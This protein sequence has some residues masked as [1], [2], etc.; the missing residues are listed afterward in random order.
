MLSDDS[1]GILMAKKRRTRQSNREYQEK[2]RRE[3]HQEQ[4]PEREYFSVIPKQHGQKTDLKKQSHVRQP[5]FKGY[6]RNQKNSR[7][8]EFR[9]S[10][11][12]NNS[13]NITPVNNN[14]RSEYRQSEERRIQKNRSDA[15]RQRKQKN[16]RQL[17]QSKEQQPKAKQGFFDY[18]LIFIVIFLVMF[19]LLMLYTA[20]IY[21]SSYFSKQCGIAVLGLVAMIGFAFIDYHKY[22]TKLMMI[23]IGGGSVFAVLLVLTPIGITLNGARRWIELG[24]I[25]LQ[26]AEIFKI[27]VILLNAIMI[28]K[29]SKVMNNIKVVGSFLLS[30]VI[31]FLF[32]YYVTQNLSSAI[33]VA[34]ITVL[35]VFVAYPGYLLFMG[36]GGGLIAVASIFVYTSLASAGSGGGFRSD[37]IIAWLAPE[38]LADPSK[39][40]QTT[41]ALY[42]IGS[43][44]F[45]GKGLG[46]GTQ[47]MI[48]PEAMNDMIFAIICEE[49]GMIGAFLVMVMFAILLY[50]LMF[51]A[52][53]SKD[54]LG[55]MIATGIFVHFMLQVVLNIGVVTNLLPST[56][57]TLPFISY[58]GTALVLLMAEVGIALNVSSKIDFEQPAL[59]RKKVRKKNV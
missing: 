7:Q 5:E 4:A 36:L 48:L 52:K 22:A 11:K 29:F 17:M 33:I 51:I 47:K 1:R 57:V 3:S 20:S 14:R 49:L 54:L 40:F 39:A 44:G 45:M 43:G 24:P 34:M 13:S 25:S 56:G 27:G 8:P 28:T 59:L 42:S 2:L 58:G 30:A 50:R 46:N 16:A 12:R 19:G 35:M 32:I 41:Q 9:K 15:S 21:T 38:K 53:N 55:G 23:I 26:P 31:E 37:R 10:N 18:T 6:E